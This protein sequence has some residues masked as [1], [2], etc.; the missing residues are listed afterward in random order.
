MPTDWIP[1]C[2]T[3]LERAIRALFLARGDATADDCYI[4][5][6]SRERIGTTAGITDIIAI[7][8]DTAP[9]LSGNEVWLVHVDNTFAATADPDGENDLLNR[10]TLDQRVGRQKLALLRGTNSLN[11]TCTDI[12]THGN[13]MATAVDATDE[14]VLFAANN[15]DMSEF[16]CLFG[17]YLGATRGNPNNE[18]SAWRERLIFEFTACPA[19]IS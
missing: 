12:T 13:A 18:S 4:S 9:E 1:N 7:K 2:G 14:A 6:E 8:S 10:V 19:A 11:E 3:Q 15:V 17:R 5:N 16:T